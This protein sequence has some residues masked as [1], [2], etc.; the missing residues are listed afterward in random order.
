MIRR[1]INAVITAVQFLTRLPLPGGMNRPDADLTLL[2]SAVIFFPL[3]GGLIGLVTGSVVWAALHVWRPFVAV[4]VGLIA[5]ALL[6]GGFHEDAVADCCDAFGGGWTRDDVLRIMKDS[7]VGSFGA[8]GL[9]L[10]VLL[11]GGCLLALPADHLI[12]AVVASAVVGRWAILLLMA[13][14]QPVPHRDGLAKDV[15]QRIGWP[16]L[17]V[18]TL[19]ALPGIVVIGWAEPVPTGLGVTAVAVVALIWTGYVLGRIGGMTG[20]CLGCGCYLGQCVFLLA[21]TA[22]V[23]Q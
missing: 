21:I 16:E 7:R 13:V 14:S 8:L 23:G 9:M 4:T 2:R 11:R 15:A 18:G 3:V 17:V 1:Q 5:E 20:D 6:T 19:L 10:A 22:G 12:P